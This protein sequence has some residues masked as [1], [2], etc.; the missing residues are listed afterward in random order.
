MSTDVEA[1]REYVAARLDPMRRTAYLICGD[2]NT[3]DDLL[4]TALIKLFRHW[5]RVSKMDSPDAYLRRMLLRAWLDERRRPWRRE[6][7]TEVM[8]DHVAGAAPVLSRMDGVND[9]LAIL[10]LLAELPPR[11]RAVLVLRYFCDLSVEQTA[12]ELGCSAGNVKSMTARA[13]AALRRWKWATRRGWRSA[14]GETIRGGQPIRALRAGDSQPDR[15]AV[16]GTV[17]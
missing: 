3:A 2:W 15:P 13:L 1:Y 10:A 7:A 8:P 4:S 16:P 11:R 5:S 12:E 9:R 17:V 6:Y 14:D